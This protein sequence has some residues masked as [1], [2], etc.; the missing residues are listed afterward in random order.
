MV[1][2]GHL[3]ASIT[4]SPTAEEILKHAFWGLICSHKSLIHTGIYQESIEN[5]DVD[6]KPYAINEVVLKDVKLVS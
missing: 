2:P 6:W 1:P 3:A 5:I 4:H